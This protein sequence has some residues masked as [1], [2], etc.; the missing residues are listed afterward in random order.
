MVEVFKTNVNQKSRS[1]GLI[2][3]LREYFPHHSVNFDLED[4]DK[5]LRVEAEFLK[6]EEI[7]DFLRKEGIMCEAL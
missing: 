5:I 3:M 1:E 4:C 2:K 6:V 7:V